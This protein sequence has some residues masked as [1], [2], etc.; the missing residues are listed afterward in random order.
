MHNDLLKKYD[1]YWRIECV[2][3]DRPN[4]RYLCNMKLGKDPFRVMRDEKKKYGFVLSL[5]EYPQ[6]I[7]TLWR[8]TMSAPLLTDFTRD[9]PEMTTLNGTMM[10]FVTNRLRTRY[11]LCRALLLTRLLVEYVETD[12]F[13]DRRP[14]FHALTRVH[15]IL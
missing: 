6:T 1:Y 10:K 3:A 4:V 11:N 12:R 7:R 15:R 14:A 2:V 8:T 13:R 5:L 9:N